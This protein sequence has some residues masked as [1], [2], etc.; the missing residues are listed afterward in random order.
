MKSFIYIFFAASV[1][2]S[3]AS[4][5][6]KVLKSRDNEYKLKM[7]EQYYTQKKYD[8]A[9]QIFDDIFPYF[10][11]DP[12]FEDMYFKYA[13]CAFYSKDYLN[14]ENLFKT[15]TESFPNSSKEDEAEFMRAYCFYMQSPKVDL[16][17]TNT[18]KAISLFQ[19]Y[20]SM[21]PE[22]PRVKDA[23]NYMDL[24]RRKLE[25]KEYK[26][27][28]L[29]YD[30]GYPDF[31]AAAVAFTTLMEDFPDS[32]KGDEYKLDVI[33]S[34]YKYA[35]QSFYAK[36]EE[37]YQKVISECDDFSDRFPESK[38]KDQVKEFKT[39]SQN[40]INKIKNEQAKATTQR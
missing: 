12:R 38:L 16:D 1:F 11:G 2:A 31:K 33:K 19:A 14:S 24:C 30:I 35:E 5:F 6:G 20:I 18:Q 34:Y 10:K 15:F 17:Q 39:L 4:E 32:E 7:A 21:H 8:K 27:A 3:C 13:Y 28:Q 37:R 40:N 29:Y 9:Q 36:Q 25:L 26:A 23:T 22:S